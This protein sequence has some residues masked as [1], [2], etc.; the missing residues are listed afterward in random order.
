[1]DRWFAKPWALPLVVAA[2]VVP[3]VAGF[4]LAGPSVGV[5]V[6][7]ITIG[8]LVLLAAR[9][10]TRD[11]IAAGERAGDDPVLVLTAV[12]IDQPATANHVA[13]LAESAGGSGSVLVLAPARASTLRRWLSDVEPARFDAQR[14]LALSLGTLAVAGCE[15][16]GRVVDEDPR[17]A[18]EDAAA[19]H[20]AALVVFVA[21]AGELD[22][23]IDDVRARIERPVQRIDVR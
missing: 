17:Q 1:M 3:T 8:A 9:S 6:G 23:A 11:P 20:G 22:E 18:I 16:E 10:R 15:A 14:S 2:I 19:V 4:A 21:P 5:A 12:P 7:G 13:T